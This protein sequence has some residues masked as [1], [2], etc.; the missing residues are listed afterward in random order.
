MSK[1]TIAP[2][3]IMYSSLYE[4]LMT[5][6]LVLFDQDLQKSTKHSLIGLFLLLLFVYIC[7]WKLNL[8]LFGWQ[9]ISQKKLQV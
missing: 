2:L 7:I 9:Y 8:V 6:R 5:L 3:L 1:Q 4:L